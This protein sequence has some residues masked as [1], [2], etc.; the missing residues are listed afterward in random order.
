MP[1]R[2]SSRIR[3]ISYADFSKM[4]SVQPQFKR[5]P[6]N[7]SWEKSRK[8]N[9]SCSFRAERQALW[10]FAYSI[11]YRQSGQYN[12][13]RLA[14]TESIAISITRPG[15]DW[16]GQEWDL[17][18]GCSTLE[19]PSIESLAGDLDSLDALVTREIRRD[20]DGFI[21]TFEA[22][23]CSQ[24]IAQSH[25]WEFRKRHIGGSWQRPGVEFDRMH[26]PLP[27]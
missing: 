3:L 5:L 21:Q 6:V 24:L 15:L 20:I 10:L 22:C 1:K 19:S 17:S 7:T 14:V 9:P 18:W 12:F 11:D 8:M 25:L 4:V 27:V 23:S 26:W 16:K 13:Y 2:C